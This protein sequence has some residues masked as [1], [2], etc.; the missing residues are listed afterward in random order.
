MVNL[1][2]SKIDNDKT[3]QR[4]V[5]HLFALE[6][7]SPGFIPSSPY[8]GA[9]GGWDGYWKGY[10]SKEAKDGVWSIQSKWTTKSF[11]DAMPHLEAEVKKE[12]EN[13]AANQVNHLRIATNA[14]L[15]VEQVLMLQDIAKDTTIGLLVWQREQLTQRIEMQ[16]FLR[17]F[18]FGDP[19]FP[20]F[21]P[22][23]IYFTEYE[24]NLLPISDSR[25]RSFEGHVD[26]AKEFLRSGTSRIL[27]VCSPG[28][29]G[30]S[31]LLRSI[32]STAHEIDRR[33][34]VWMAK[35][36]VRTMQDAL[37]DE[38]GAGRQYLI[39]FDDADRFIDEIKPI[40][41]FL[42][43][44]D[45]IKV[46]LAVRTSG[47]ESVFRSVTETHLRPFCEEIRI[48]DWSK[49]DLITL[50]RTAA[51]R[52]QVQNESTIVAC[53]P[54][55]FLIVWIGGR[56]SG[57]SDLPLDNIKHYLVGDM[58]RETEVCL[59][60][61]GEDLLLNL[62]CMVPLSGSDGSLAAFASVLEEGHV[63]EKVDKL[64]KAGLL[65]VVGRNVRF[66]PDMKGDLYLAEKLEENDEG[67][68]R[69]LMGTWLP[70]YPEKIL[71]N[72][73]SAARFGNV[74]SVE[75]SLSNIT[76]SWVKG[77][78]VPFRSRKEIL[79]LIERL[80]V[81]IPEQCMDVLDA[82]LKSTEALT[83]DDFG[84]AISEL[85][86]ITAPR[87]RVLEAIRAMHATSI[88]GEY[89]N[90]HP[91]S[92][93]RI[94]VSPLQNSI[95]TIEETLN[96]INQW[97][98]EPDRTRIELV[99]AALC[100]VLA[101][102]HEYTEPGILSMTI[103]ERSLK[104]TPEVRKL[105]EHAL[106]ILT[107]MID[108]NLLEVKL[109]A[110]TVAEEIGST[111]MGSI[112]EAKLPLSATIREEREFVVKRMGGLLSPELDF[113]LMNKIE[114]LFLT[115]WA[116]RIPGTD[117]VGHYLETMPRSTEYIAFSYYASSMCVVENFAELKDNAPTEGRWQWFV[118][119]HMR[120]FD[121]PERKIKDL[122]AI[123]NGSHGSPQQVVEL[124]CRLDQTLLA[125]EHRRHPP[126][127][128]R[129]VKINPALFSAI[130]KD[131]SLW[132]QVPEWFSGEIR[133]A[134]AEIDDKAFLELAHEVLL[135]L[136][137]TQITKVETFLSSLCRRPL[138]QDTMYSGLAK[139]LDEGASEKIALLKL[140]T[141][142]L[143][144]RIRIR[145]RSGPVTPFTLYGW[146]SALLTR[147]SSAIRSSA[148][149]H[150]TWISERLESVY[151]VIKLLRLVL[152]REKQLSDAMV[153]NL[154]I[155][156]LNKGKNIKSLSSRTVQYL[157]RD[158][159]DRLERLATLDYPAQDLLEFACPRIDILAG[160]LESRIQTSIGTSVTE[161][162]PVPF[163][164][165][166]LLGRLMK[167][168]DD[169][170]AFMTT[171]ASWH[172]R[173]SVWRHYSRV[174]MQEVCKTTEVERYT[175][176]Y[177]RK[178]LEKGSIT[179]ALMACEFL[180]LSAD[181]FRIF[182]KVGE[183]AISRGQVK[184]IESL[185]HSKILPPGAWHSSLGE[186]PPELVSRRTVFQQMRVDINPRELNAIIDDC[187]ERID[188]TIEMDLRADEEILNPRA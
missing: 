117:E 45:S 78:I 89:N 103:G 141:L 82:F 80:A 123:L 12:L 118:H 6:C 8:I 63:Q 85:I 140:N 122:V 152:S 108:H 179:S 86:E 9:D 185:L 153:N 74:P 187:I 143:L 22:W 126:I 95:Q 120:H 26:K 37:Q 116:Q 102:T 94:C 114:Q 155:L 35:G 100:E 112:D 142:L 177:V 101:A 161:Y 149:F 173:G 61:S 1:D 75:K 175:E 146:L 33:T 105:R 170:E 84:P 160:F 176:E 21:V 183:Q 72:V 121:E 87:Q 180:P 167:S 65:R 54:N 134:L 47:R 17:H 174:L 7:D 11:K 48:S 10:Y 23:N 52:E 104:N 46:I 30:K 131:G 107:R 34:Q 69:T 32:A 129:W 50:L 181:T 188:E 49:D 162:R 14:E 57:K 109:A 25:I 92:L 81:V 168:F 151:L 158:L 159:L 164:G 62:A 184:E 3:F 79:S 15:K 110:I 43:G 178:Q 58:D 93:V 135:E 91:Q 73:A 28:G 172:E 41:S 144:D 128:T 4:L 148:I 138:S 157:E 53:Y 182:N 5:N 169:Y 171:I 77:D 29:Y 60:A 156:I 13:A 36:G 55:P 111:R 39:V 115:W 67:K 56:I 59:G 83:T 132:Q 64:V 27:L 166:P 90:Y 38:I 98:D 99:S 96:I 165:I 163:R 139:A 51:N 130:R 154:H 2:W 150:L 133:L 71:I 76:R 145:L 124:L 113:A 20:K 147:G 137:D 106:R 31:H 19:Q 127:A 119:T 40:L 125:F 24:P 44:N 136:P 97:L 70:I 88:R 16:P 42:R 66:N 68:L 18:F 186:P